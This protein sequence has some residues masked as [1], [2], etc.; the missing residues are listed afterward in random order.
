MSLKEDRAEK[1]FC[2]PLDVS[3]DTS[4]SKKKNELLFRSI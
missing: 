4:V 1:Q 3:P 2:F